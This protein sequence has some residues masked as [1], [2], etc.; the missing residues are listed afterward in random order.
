MAK[1]IIMFNLKEDVSEEAYM[2]WVMEHKAPAQ[3]SVNSGIRF[4]MLQTTGCET[5]DGRKDEPPQHAK[6]PYK[7]CVIMEV[8]SLEDWGRDVEAS[9]AL[10]QNIF[11]TWVTKYVADFMAIDAEELYDKV[12]D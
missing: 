10:M 7:Y 4:T 12:S 8:T 6:S 9:E 11:P 5:G 1:Q 3:L 2:E